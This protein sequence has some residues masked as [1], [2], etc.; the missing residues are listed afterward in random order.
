MTKQ[1]LIPNYISVT[2]TFLNAAIYYEVISLFGLVF[3]RDFR[4][5]QTSNRVCTAAFG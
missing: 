1:Y 4:G 2:F 3:R 5:V